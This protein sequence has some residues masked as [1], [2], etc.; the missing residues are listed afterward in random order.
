MAMAESGSPQEKHRQIVRVAFE[1]WRD[2]TAPITDLFAPEMVWR[3][4]GHSFASR[5]CAS[6]QKFID[7]VLPPFGT[8][9]S[10]AQP[11][12]PVNLRGVYADGDMVI[13][14]WDGRGVTTDGQP[15][16]NSYA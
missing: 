4:E 9:F 5:E 1:A 6:R 15:Y 13:V 8:R 12:R 11:F 14:L 2:G 7:E 10:V 3:I 16:A